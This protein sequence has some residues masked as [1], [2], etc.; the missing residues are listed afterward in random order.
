VYALA[1]CVPPAALPAAADRVLAGAGG[2]AVLDD[3]AA[4]LQRTLWFQV[5]VFALSL[6]LMLAL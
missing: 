6:L 3:F 1:R 5:A 2:A 4:S